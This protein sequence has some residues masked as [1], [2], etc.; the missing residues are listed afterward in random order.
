MCLEIELLS[1]LL[2]VG[3]NPNALVSSNKSI[4]THLIDQLIEHDEPN[5]ARHD[6]HIKRIDSIKKMI[7]LLIESGAY[8]NESLLLAC[9]HNR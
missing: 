8:V 9:R 7:R 4:M 3:A 2:R 6:D 5:D 1:S